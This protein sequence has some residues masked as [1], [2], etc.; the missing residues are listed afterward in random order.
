MKTKTFL[1]LCLFTGIGLTQLSAQLQ[2]PDPYAHN[3]RGTGATI[4]TGGAEYVDWGVP[5]FCH[6]E[7]VELL[8]VDCTLH[9]LDH[10]MNGNWISFVI[11][12]HGEAKSDATG[13]VF[14]FNEQFKN[15]GMTTPPWILSSK[16][17]LRGD[18]GSHYIM[19][20]T[21]DITN[22]IFTIQKGL[23]F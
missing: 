3:D 22:D 19:S 10:W 15:Y 14:I 7:F 6:G 17:N 21:Y 11:S 20:I 23:C 12:L 4:T 1:L 16:L 18:K 13:E 2:Y 8:L 9:Y 5:V